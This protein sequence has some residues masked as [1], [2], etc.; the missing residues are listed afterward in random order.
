[1]KG[2]ICEQPKQLELKEMNVPAKKDGQ[3]IIRV[4]R[5]GICGTD[6]HAYRGVQPFFSYPR[7]LGHELS[8]VIEEIEENNAGFEK[9]DQISILPYLSCGECVACR[10]GKENCCVNMKVIGVHEDGGM[11]EFISIPI[12]HLLKTNNLT[13]DQ[14]AIIEPLA[15]SAHAIRRANIKKN[16]WVLVIGAG[17]IG[18]GVMNFARQ[19]GAKVIA[20][21]MNNERLVFCEKWAKVAITVSALNNPLEK[22]MDITQG[23]LPTIVFDATGNQQSM[24]QAFNYVAHGGKLIYV[25]LVKN[26]I[27]F[28]DPDFHSKELTLMGSR[29]ATKEDFHYVIKKLETGGIAAEGYIT[30]RCSFDQFID[31]FEAWLSPDSKIIKGVI[32]L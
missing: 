24:N 7:V 9:G 12:D 4:K 19:A 2:I 26:D 28:S 3:A 8:G 21:D 14:S 32:E 10:N 22:L 31:H 20:M 16:E 18:L 13:L 5:I 29:N 30:H 15:I 27:T 25:G 11:C 23:E 6:M 17:P 1:M